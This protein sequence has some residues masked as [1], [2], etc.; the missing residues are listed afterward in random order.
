MDE[1]RLFTFLPRVPLGRF[2]TGSTVISQVRSL[3]FLYGST[4][5]H[6]NDAGWDLQQQEPDNTRADNENAQLRAPDVT[7]SP[8]SVPP[9]AASPQ[10]NEPPVDMQSPRNVGEDGASWRTGQDDESAVE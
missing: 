3:V 8:R 9:V 6:Y 7:S 2:F 4:P 5:E 10:R 1:I